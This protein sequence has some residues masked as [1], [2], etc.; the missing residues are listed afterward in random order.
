MSI[1]KEFKNYVSEQIK[2]NNSW[3]VRANA[4]RIESMCRAAINRSSYGFHCDDKQ[5]QPSTYLVKEGKV[6]FI[7]QKP[8]TEIGDGC[9]HP[10][11]RSIFNRANDIITDAKKSFVPSMASEVINQ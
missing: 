6:I 7:E 9:C 1:K 10:L 3:F 11:Y 2:S 4:A 5:G 8:N